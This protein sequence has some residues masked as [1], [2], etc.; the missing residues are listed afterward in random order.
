MKN[1]TLSIPD[2]ILRRSREYAKKHGTTLNQMV[3]N[4]LKKTVAE[5]EEDLGP[6]LDK[7]MDKMGVDTSQLKF[8]RD[9]L[10]ER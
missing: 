5:Q 7:M 8:K 3:R 1:I 6:K 2:D 9:D 10:Y 4:L